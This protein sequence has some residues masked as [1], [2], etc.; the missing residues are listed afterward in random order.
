MAG[1]DKK[2][3]VW[4]DAIEKRNKEAETL[5]EA[6]EFFAELEKDKEIEKKSNDPEEEFQ[7]RVI[8]KEVEKVK[9][10]DKNVVRYSSKKPFKNTAKRDTINSHDE[11]LFFDGE[12][13]SKKS[14]WSLFGVVLSSI[15]IACVLIPLIV[16]M[17]SVGLVIDSVFTSAEIL[18][19]QIEETEF[20]IKHKESGG[21]LQN[22]S[23]EG[24]Q[25]YLSEDII[26]TF[27]LSDNND[28]VNTDKTDKKK[29]QDKDGEIY[30]QSEKYFNGE[31]MTI[32]LDKKNH[33][34]VWSDSEHSSPLYFKLKN[35]ESNE[36]AISFGDYPYYLGLDDGSNKIEI[37]YEPDWFVIEAKTEPITTGKQYLSNYEDINKHSDL[38]VENLELNEEG[39]PIGLYSIKN[40][41]WLNT[42]QPI[43][44]D[45]FYKVNFKN[46]EYYT[47]FVDV[48][49][50]MFDEA[51]RFED[52]SDTNMY[53]KV[54]SDANMSFASYQTLPIS[55]S[56]DW[57]RT[58]PEDLF[59][60]NPNYSNVE[61][62]GI[63]NG[64]NW[65][66]EYPVLSFDSEKNEFKLK[67]HL[68]N[69]EVNSSIFWLVPNP[70]NLTQYAIYFPNLGGFL[71]IYE[72]KLNLVTEYET[73]DE[74]GITQTVSY[75]IDNLTI[76]D[77]ET[78][79]YFRIDHSPNKNPE[80][81]S[82]GSSSDE[83]LRGLLKDD[84]YI[85]VK[86]PGLIAPGRAKIKITESDPEELAGYWFVGFNYSWINSIASQLNINNKT[87]IEAYVSANPWD[88]S[89]IIYDKGVAKN[90][91]H[92]SK[93]VL[94]DL[95][96]ATTYQGFL[97]TLRK[98]DGGAGKHMTFDYISPFTTEQ[99]FRKPDW[100]VDIPWGQ[101]PWPDIPWDKIP[102][103]E[104]P[105]DKI[106]WPDLPW[107]DLIPGI[108]DLIPDFPEL[109][110]VDPGDLS[111]LD[112]ILAEGD[113][114]ID[115]IDDVIV[116]LVTGIIPW[117]DADSINMDAVDDVILEVIIDG[118]NDENK[119]YPLTAGN[120]ENSTETETII[121]DSTDEVGNT[122]D[123]IAT[124]QIL[125]DAQN[126]IEVS[127]QFH[128]GTELGQTTRL[129]LNYEVDGEESGGKIVLKD[130]PVDGEVYTHIFTDLRPNTKYH[131][132][133]SY[134][135][136]F[137]VDVTQ[138][139]DSEIKEGYGEYE[140]YASTQRNPITEES[141]EVNYDTSVGLTTSV[142][143]YDDSLIDTDQIR[144]II[145]DVDNSNA[146]LIDTGWI[147][148]TDWESYTSTEIP[149]AQFTI[150]DAGQ[151][152]S[153][154]MSIPDLNPFTSGGY[155][156][157]VWGKMDSYNSGWGIDSI[158]NTLSPEEMPEF[159]QSI[160][161]ITDE[162]SNL[163][164]ID[165]VDESGVM[166]S[167]E[168]GIKGAKINKNKNNSTIN[169]IIEGE[170][171]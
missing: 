45:S 24:E 82:D 37:T 32:S 127:V 42:Y 9:L 104:L 65:K 58:I 143:I 162:T 97:V 15:L 98:N 80:H 17:A 112:E 171:R 49:E 142:D 93:M 34:P 128:Q 71:S 70:N 72:D 4:E 103:P 140:M 68:S 14:R 167:E 158:G 87:M 159:S 129:L 6:S 29:K 124:D 166:P 169:V 63:L 53:I 122:P 33:K 11:V 117:L 35:N 109:T 105:W 152:T 138:N 22:P 125:I 135:N 157:H 118:Y 88:F 43:G 26:D 46:E 13:N 99:G 64:E 2:V 50:G 160:T 163:G 130:D 60:E 120:L 40:E 164:V 168:E 30:I 86:T 77:Y 66:T 52:S 141:Y 107:G 39:N 156:V 95:D 79:D 155:N 18:G 10:V 100:D 134:T 96:K 145:E 113:A 136:I 1:K 165:L 84:D 121:W 102:W 54:D 146:T 81:H 151:S 27:V 23:M 101:I 21:Y 111:N 78:L 126:S 12:E 44:E 76:E 149:D 36:F 137:D 115:D 59:I 131:F 123:D 114:I 108:D 154:I 48:N 92:T 3:N 148:F 41:K 5:R 94:R 147:L 25:L 90:K 16:I 139:E 31:Y 85:N 110:N 57:M 116:N 133:L 144:V 55:K 7:P 153:Y 89:S 47:P 83:S 61:E 56:L 51:I 8:E 119:D 170:R 73:V 19:I 161:T 67:Q 132:W 20:A 106:P 74:F 150:A 62:K 28:N 69:E 38:Y 91:K 75:D